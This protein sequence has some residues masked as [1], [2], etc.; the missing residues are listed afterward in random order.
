MAKRP[1]NILFVKPERR[2]AAFNRRYHEAMMRPPVRCIVCG[3]PDNDWPERDG[4]CCKCWCAA[5]CAIVDTARRLRGRTPD[6]PEVR[7]LIHGM[8]SDPRR[9]PSLKDM[10]FHKRQGG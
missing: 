6:V 7:T 10:V 5:W 8:V 9:L 3:A 1:R 2:D 4:L